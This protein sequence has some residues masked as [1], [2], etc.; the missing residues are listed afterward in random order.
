MLSPLSPSVSAVRLTQRESVR[1]ICAPVQ[2]RV[3]AIMTLTRPV[4]L[5]ALDLPAGYAPGHVRIAAASA[6]GSRDAT[7][8]DP[9]RLPRASS[10]P[11]SPTATLRRA[12]SHMANLRELKARVA[13]S[14]AMLRR[15]GSPRIRRTPSSPTA[16]VANL[17]AQWSPQRVASSQDQALHAPFAP[18]IG[19]PSDI[20]TDPAEP[21]SKAV[22]AT[23]SSV[24]GLRRSSSCSCSGGH[25]APPLRVP[26]LSRPS[27]GLG[28]LPSSTLEKPIARRTS[29]LCS[30]SACASEHRAAQAPRQAS[31]DLARAAIERPATAAAMSAAWAAAWAA[32]EASHVLSRQRTSPPRGG[33]AGALGGARRRGDAMGCANSVDARPARPWTGQSH[34][35]ATQLPRRTSSRSMHPSAFRPTP[36]GSFNRPSTSPSARRA[37][38]HVPRVVASRPMTAGAPLTNPLTSLSVA[39]QQAFPGGPRRLFSD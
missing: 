29:A 10:P 19:A 8:T 37:T 1:P 13:K 34:Q 2:R 17:H 5:S 24:G 39:G 3:L 21:A 22:M 14:S 33:S 4:S 30:T 9:A 16:R 12:A 38:T 36:R 15:I 26:G 6:A 25:S 18:P 35:R 7:G 11:S 27:T 23:A 20:S 31:P 32:S 28:A